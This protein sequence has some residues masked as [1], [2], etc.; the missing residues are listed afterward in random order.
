MKR[1]VFFLH[2]PKSAG[3]SVLTILRSS[4]AENEICPQPPD[5]AWTVQWAT[6]VGGY[7]L[8]SGHFDAGFLEAI[9]TEGTKLTMLRHPVARIISIYDFWRSYRWEHIRATLPDENG[10]A[11]AK[12]SNLSEFLATTS[13]FVRPNIYNATA[14]QLLG[15]QRFEA[16]W[17][18][19]DELIA[20][21][22]RALATY[23]WVGVT[24]SFDQSIAALCDL[25]ERAAPTSLPVENPTYVKSASNPSLEPVEKTEPTERERRSI[26]EGNRIDMALYLE[27]QRRL[28]HGPA[29]GVIAT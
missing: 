10:P 1:P 29:R 11:I 27:G 15:A 17:P 22:T 6:S 4:F 2:V 13:N 28:A 24:E 25:L 16:L 8:Y 14:R 5:G 20:E 3:T 23:T 21:A 26:L 19:E 18:D 7:Q 9:G 12:Q